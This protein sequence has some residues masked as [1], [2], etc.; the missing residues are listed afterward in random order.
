[1]T[2]DE[3]KSVLDRVLTWPPEEQEMA[4]E[5]LLLMEA[6]HGEVYH[7][8]DEEWAAIEEGLAQAERGE[9][10]TDEEMEAVWKR[11]GA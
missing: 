2:K 1:M 11:F 5:A 10:A 4:A 3:I 7:P 9:F 6:R 8:D